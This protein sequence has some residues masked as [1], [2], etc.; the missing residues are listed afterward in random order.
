MRITNFTKANLIFKQAYALNTSN[1]TSLTSNNTRQLSVTFPSFSV[2]TNLENN[3]FKFSYSRRIQRP[4]YLYLNPYYIDTYNV[5]VGN[6]EL[7]PQFTDAFEL[8]WIKNKNLT[9]LF[10]NFSKDEMYQIIN[11]DK[12]LKSQP[13]IMTILVNQKHRSLL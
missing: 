7:T 11:Y 9:F 2:N 5:S 3:Q 10:A 12:I 8:V 6:P 13:C 1:A 4:R